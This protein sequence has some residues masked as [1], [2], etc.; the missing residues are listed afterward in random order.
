MCVDD[1]ATQNVSLNHL[2]IEMLR[3]NTLL[4]IKSCFNGEVLS[5][6]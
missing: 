4:I 5:E 1:V 6:C 3:V 2:E